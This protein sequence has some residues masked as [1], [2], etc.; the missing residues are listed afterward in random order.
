MELAETSDLA[1]ACLTSLGQFH[2]PLCSLCSY[3]MRPISR[4]YI[5][6]KLRALAHAGFFSAW[7]TLLTLLAY[8]CFTLQALA[9]ISL[10]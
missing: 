3:I 2:A 7:N 4:C 8:L 10:P 9:Q 1:P 6:S 5:F